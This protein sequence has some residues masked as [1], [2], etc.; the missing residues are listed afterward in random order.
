MFDSATKFSTKPIHCTHQES[1]YDLFNKPLQS[2]TAWTLGLSLP[3]LHIGRVLH[4]A[5]AFM[6]TTCRASSPG[7]QA[8]KHSRI[9]TPHFATKGSC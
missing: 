8:C 3:D 4:F 6:P 2:M 5:G 1:L 9:L 7:L